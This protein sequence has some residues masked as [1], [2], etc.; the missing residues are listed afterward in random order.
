MYPIH[1][2]AIR[3][4]C[5]L[6][7]GRLDHHSIRKPF[8]HAF[9]FSQSKV[10]SPLKAASKREISFSIIKINTAVIKAHSFG[11]RGDLL[12]WKMR[13]L[14]KTLVWEA[15]SHTPSSLQ[16]ETAGILHHEIFWKNS[17]SFSCRISA[18]SL[19]PG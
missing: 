2:R 6:K 14:T 11:R 19:H 10:T 8:P 18:H 12:V 1:A 17:P 9:N 16:L 3:K 13:F 5:Q 7:L 4:S 15:P